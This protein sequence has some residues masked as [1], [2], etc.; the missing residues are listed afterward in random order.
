M[1]AA[2]PAHVAATIGGIAGCGLAAAGQPGWAALTILAGVAI[3][4]VP[5]D[6]RERRIPTLLVGTGAVAVV[7]AAAIT[8]IRD[9][10]WS[11]LAHLALGAAVVGGAFVVVHL[12]SPRSLGFGDVRLAGLTGAATAY[13]TGSVGAAA[14]ATALAAI[15]VSIVTVTTRMRTAPFA[16]Y[17]L[18][19]AAGAVVLSLL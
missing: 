4:V 11:P 19:G 17:L 7:A 18:A 8:S 16:P 15:T 12:F 2:P 14:V 10:T 3:A 1:T 5:T 6:L 9:G 13:G